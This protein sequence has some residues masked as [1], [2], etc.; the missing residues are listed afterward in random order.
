MTS[1]GDGLPKVVSAEEWQRKLA[2]LT[3]QEKD[4]LGYRRTLTDE[5]LEGIHAD[6]DLDG[7]DDIREMLDAFTSSGIDLRLHDDVIR[8]RIP[9]W[10]DDWRRVADALRD[11][12]REIHEEL[13]RSPAA[14]RMKEGSFSDIR[15]TVEVTV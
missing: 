5:E 10:G 14:G 9:R 11:R 15:G 12:H 7:T 3:V 8:C 4:A 1:G 6:R 13:I 2:E